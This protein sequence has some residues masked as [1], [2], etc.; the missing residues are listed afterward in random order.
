MLSVIAFI[1]PVNVGIDHLK[2]E[3][4][5]EAGGL[6][7]LRWCN[8]LGEKSPRDS[9]KKQHC[10]SPVLEDPAPLPM[11]VRWTTGCAERC[12]FFP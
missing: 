7:I 8:L 5:N 12:C 10:V 3:Y 4:R 1:I 9:Y 6:P 2:N 11:V